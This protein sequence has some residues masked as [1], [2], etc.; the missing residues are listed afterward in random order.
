M[1]VGY[2][3]RG[4]DPV[5]RGEV[6]DRVLDGLV[7][8]AERSLAVEDFTVPGRAGAGDADSGADARDAVVG[9]ALVA[10]QSP[11]FMTASRVIVLRDVG[12]LTTA[13]AEP[14]VRYLA[15]PLDT[16]VL[17]FVAG[18]GRLPANLTKAWKGIVEE[19]GPESEKTLDVLVQHAKAAGLNLG[20]DARQVIV[21]HLGE[22]AGRVPQ[23]VELLRS[24]YGDDTLLGVAEIEP[25][26]GE[27]GAIP[28][29]QLTN[30]IESGDVAGSLEILHR[31]LH[32][33][34][35]QGK[36]MHP[37]QV[38]GLLH[39]H[40]RRLLVLDDPAIRSESD[41]VSALGG[42]VKPY[43]A[44][45]AMEHSRALGTDRLRKAYDALGQA[46]LDLKGATGMPEDAVI[47]VLVA[48]LAGLS[49]RARGSRG[50]GA[51]RRPVRALHQT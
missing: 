14:F 18:G 8:H 9:S 25:Y 33:T 6:L 7:P 40:Y 46:D 32:V 30:A 35:A 29:Y 3:V 41:A 36:P 43:P 22:D 24:V 4:D 21:D 10:A 50:S 34:G 27:A 39:H 23:F 37:L 42:K 11:P 19:T 2:F 26:L 48:R 49:N 38:L 5:L 47:E 1:T 44:R 20:A 12:N 31:L 17:V 13:D 15:D 28:V 45:K 16:T 51:R